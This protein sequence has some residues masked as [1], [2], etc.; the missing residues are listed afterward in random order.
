MF[1]PLSMEI[2]CVPSEPPITTQPVLTAGL[3]PEIHEGSRFPPSLAFG[4]QLPSHLVAMGEL[5]RVEPKG[6]PSKVP[7]LPSFF[8]F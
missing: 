1:A 6:G 5:Y 3:S 2:I 8:S 7:F 4:F